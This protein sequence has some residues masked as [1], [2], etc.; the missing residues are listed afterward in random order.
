MHR[1]ILQGNRTAART[2][3][4]RLPPQRS[5]TC[6]LTKTSPFSVS[7]QERAHQD[8]GSGA[9][10]PVGE[11]PQDQGPNPS[12]HKEHPGPPPPD[13]KGAQP[14]I[15]SQNEPTGEHEDH[16]KKHNEDGERRA[17]KSHSKADDPVDKEYWKRG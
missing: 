5:V 15:H 12:E 7:H 8:Y 2:I 16:V 9:G 10:N 4:S 14:R 3:S 13:V 11:N 1:T 6:Q 17:E